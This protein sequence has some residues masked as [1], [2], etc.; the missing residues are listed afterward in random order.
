MSKRRNRP[1]TLGMEHLDPQTRLEGA[2]IGHMLQS[3]RLTKGDIAEITELTD[4]AAACS[5]TTPLGGVRSRIQNFSGFRGRSVRDSANSI[6][7][8]WC[9]RSTG[10]GKWLALAN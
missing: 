3:P 10:V 6:E 9:R 8:Y 1:P 2:A 4:I 5:G 7:T